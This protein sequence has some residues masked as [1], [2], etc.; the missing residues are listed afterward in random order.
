VEVFGICPQ[1]RAEQTSTTYANQNDLEIPH[2]PEQEQ[3]SC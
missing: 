2:Y 1:C 3:E